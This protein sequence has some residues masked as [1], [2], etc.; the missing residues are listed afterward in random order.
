M[1]AWPH[2][3]ALMSTGVNAGHSKDANQPNSE[4]FCTNITVL[5]LGMVTHTK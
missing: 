3:H 4:F 1:E 2:A 5:N